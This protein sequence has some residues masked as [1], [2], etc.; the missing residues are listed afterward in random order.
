[1]PG[2]A[3][4]DARWLFV[5]YAGSWGRHAVE[6]S[7][8]PD[9]A[10]AAV[11]ALGWT[12]GWHVDAD[13]IRIETVDRFIPCSDFFTLDVADSIGKPAAPTDVAAFLDRHPELVGTISIPGI[14]TP[15]LTTRAEVE[16]I[17]GK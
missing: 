6:E 14:A 16:R 13:P 11:A 15:F 10:K 3:P 5:E 8:L 17:V 7:R 9:A 2:T 12:K 1:M 4:V